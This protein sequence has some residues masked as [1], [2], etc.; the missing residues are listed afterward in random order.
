MN[1]TTSISAPK[2]RKYLIHSHLF[3][4]RLTYNPSMPLFFNLPD[5]TFFCLSNIVIQSAIIYKHLLSIHTLNRSVVYMNG[6]K[7]KMLYTI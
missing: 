1:I 6:M 5:S 3:Q 2:N 7:R 4:T